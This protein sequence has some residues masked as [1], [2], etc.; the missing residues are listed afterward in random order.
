MVENDVL[1]TEHELEAVFLEPF[2][3]PLELVWLIDNRLVA[4][5]A[6]RGN[7]RHTVV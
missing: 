2:T 7:G 6:G 4:G 3:Q 1:G 5:D